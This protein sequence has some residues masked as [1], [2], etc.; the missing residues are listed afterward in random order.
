V[1]S[2]AH[3][4][5]S[6]QAG[7]TTIQFNHTGFPG[8]RPS[9]WPRDGALQQVGRLKGGAPAYA[10]RVQFTASDARPYVVTSDRSGPEPAYRIGQQLQVLYQPDHPDGARIEDFAS[11]QVR[12]I[13]LAVLF[14]LHSI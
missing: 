8:E 4:E 14:R 3:F 5:L 13:Q 10:P 6:E 7:V 9:I 2:I 11:S 1:Y 12:A